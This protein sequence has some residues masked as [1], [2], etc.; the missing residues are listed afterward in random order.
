MN[1]EF[2]VELFYRGFWPNTHHTHVFFRHCFYG[3]AGDGDRDLT[4]HMHGRAGALGNSF[5]FLNPKLRRLQARRVASFFAIFVVFSA[6]IR[7]RL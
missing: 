6:I 5:S 1:G 3:C 2:D 7:G 4:R